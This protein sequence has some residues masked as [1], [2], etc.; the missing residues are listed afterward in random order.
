MDNKLQFPIV[1][2]LLVVGL[3]GGFLWGNQKAEKTFTE[4]SLLNSP[5][6]IPLSLVELLSS[7]PAV[8]DFKA[9]VE[10]AGTILELKD[11][12]IIV[13]V[14]NGEPIEIVT[15]NLTAFLNTA[16]NTLPPVIPI[17]SSQDVK[18]GDQ[19]IILATVDEE[20]LKARIIRPYIQTQ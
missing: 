11:N 19:V 20:A 12:K 8:L 10:I 7:N 2:A 18:A 16:D 6:G 5:Q 14:K 13:A 17:F 9:D 1:A 4:L 3:A 15:D